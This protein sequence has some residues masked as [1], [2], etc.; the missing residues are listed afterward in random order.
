MKDGLNIYHLSDDGETAT[1]A[2]HISEMH[3]ILVA[4][5]DRLEMMCNM[6]TPVVDTAMAVMTMEELLCIAKK[7]KGFNP[8][9]VPDDAR[10]LDL[11]D[12]IVN[13]VRDEKEVKK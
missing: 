11:K 13:R 2:L 3:L 8:D 9:R 10:L 4:L 1:L 5:D 6:D 12:Y 7:M